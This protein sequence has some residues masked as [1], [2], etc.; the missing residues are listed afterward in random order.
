MKSAELVHADSLEFIITLPEN[1]IDAI[2]T[3]PAY[4][5]V[6]NNAWDNQWST[7]AYYLAWLHEFFAA[8]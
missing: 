4:Y 8:F 7:V 2:I 5:R 6:K 3:D 1:S